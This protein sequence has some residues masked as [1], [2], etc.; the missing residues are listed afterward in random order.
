MTLDT[1]VRIPGPIDIDELRIFCWRQMGVPED[2]EP[3]RWSVDENRTGIT[4][5]ERCSPG[6]AHLSITYNLD[7]QDVVVSWITGWSSRT[8]AGQ[9][10]RE[11]HDRLVGELAGWLAARELSGHRSE[12]S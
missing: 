10:P 11:L 7:G 2:T 9:A 1:T 3:I 5:P 12:C 8:S 4:P 6:G